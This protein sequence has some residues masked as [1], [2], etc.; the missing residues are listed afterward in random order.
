MNAADYI[1][2]PF[3]ILSAISAVVS[4]LVA[5]ITLLRFR[6]S[7]GLFL[8][9]SMFAVTYWS[10]FTIFEY[11]AAEIASKVF[12]AQVS[13]VGVVTTPVLFY[14]STLEFFRSLDQLK[15][16]QILSLFLIPIISLVLTTT[17][18]VHHLVWTGYSPI[19]PV[20]NL[21]I[22]GHGWWFWLGVV[23]YSYILIFVAAFSLIRAAARTIYPFRIQ[24]FLLLAAGLTPIVGNI[25]YVFDISIIKGY[26]PTSSLFTISGLLFAIAIYRF[27]LVELAPMAF[28]QV[29][30]H[31]VNAIFIVDHKNRLV[32]LNIVAKQ[33]LAFGQD[34]ILEH[35]LTKKPAIGDVIHFSERII[36]AQSDVTLGQPGSL[37]HYLVKITNLYEKKDVHSGTVIVLDDVTTQRNA[38]LVMQ[39]AIRTKERDRLIQ[40][41]NKELDTLFTSMQGRIESI[42]QEIKSANYPAALSRLNALLVA[43]QGVDREVRKSML[44]IN[45]NAQDVRGFSSMLKIYLDRFQVIAGMRVTTS[46]P[47]TSIDQLLSQNAFSILFHIIQDSLTIANKITKANLVQFIFTIEEKHLGVLITEDGDI[48]PEQTSQLTL[49]LEKIKDHC[50]KCNAVAEIRTTPNQG[51]QILLKF[52]LTGNTKP[53]NDLAGVRVMLADDHTLFSEGF[54]N[55]L[56]GQG[57]NV[58]GIVQTVEEVSRLTSELQPE[59]LIIDPTIP[60]LEKNHTI[61][62]VKES[63]PKTIIVCLSDEPEDTLLTHTIQN[64]IHGFLLKDQPT[65]EIM[66]GLWSIINGE[67]T[68]APRLTNR[69]ANAFMLPKVTQ[70]DQARQT[71]KAAGLSGKQI[72]ILEMVAAG[73][74]YKEIAAEISLSESAIKYHSERILTLLKVKNRGE[75]IKYAYHIGLVENRRKEK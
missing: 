18:E 31:L 27:Q 58:I 10:F 70:K 2:S 71:L 35:P 14:L 56:T 52:P 24:A 12:W 46:L 37:R 17:N 69:L 55:L 7:G 48:S 26:D 51:T 42:G 23:G 28:Q 62:K 15:R 47:E 13:Y 33:I 3:S 19:D 63:S 29:M 73:R 67:A 9:L 45:T 61:A 4:F 74:I 43:T 38:Q 68:F 40:D 8:S 54:S 21:S 6:K 5:T 20:T 57:M 64:G 66:A 59:V 49:G 60:S 41:M 75:L 53:K 44:D 34:Q 30:D 39:K 72:E 16:N 50:D 65:E 11:S 22:F 36:E 1:Y 32:Y 25:A